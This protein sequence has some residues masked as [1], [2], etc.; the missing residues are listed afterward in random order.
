L[1]QISVS[2]ERPYLS[3][4]EIAERWGVHRSTVYKEVSSGNLRAKRFGKNIRVHAGE[5]ER[6]EAESD[7]ENGQYRT[8]PMKGKKMPRRRKRRE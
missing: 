8:S 5:V 2:A 6:F 7:W 1:E 3:I 4:D